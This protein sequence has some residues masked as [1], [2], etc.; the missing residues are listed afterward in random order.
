MMVIK[1]IGKTFAEEVDV[2]IDTLCNLPLDYARHDDD[3]NILHFDSE[4]ESQKSLVHLK[5]FTFSCHQADVV[6]DGLKI[7]FVQKQAIKP[8]RAYLRKRETY[9][10]RHF[11]DQVKNLERMLKADERVYRRRGLTFTFADTGGMQTAME[12][13]N[14]D[15][16]PLSPFGYGLL[17]W[18][19]KDPLS[20]EVFHRKDVPYD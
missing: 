5:H 19:Q 8:S 16:T 1:Y 18:K 6:L 11:R 12:C 20:I 17:D 3:P 4:Q 9:L 14:L 10:Q 2:L 13:L 15:P 7:V